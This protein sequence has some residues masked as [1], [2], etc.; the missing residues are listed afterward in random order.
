ML[1]SSLAFIPFFAIST[2][3]MAQTYS[4]PGG[5][6][7]FDESGDFAGTISD[8]TPVPGYPDESEITDITGTVSSDGT[9]SGTYSGVASYN[10]VDGSGDVVS[11]SEPYSGSFTGGIADGGDYSVSWGG[12]EPGS[13]TG[14]LSGF[15]L[16]SGPVTTSVVSSLTSPTEDIISS[17]SNSTGESRDYYPAKNRR[18]AA[19]VQDPNYIA[20]KLSEIS[21]LC[22]QTEVYVVDCIAERLEV[23]EKELRGLPGQSEV[24]KV[25]RQTALDLHS[26]A[27]EHR[28]P[29]T[30]RA[31]VRTQDNSLQTSR[32]LTAIAPDQKEAALIKALTIIEEAET[33]LLRSASTSSQAAQFQDI[34][35]ALGSNK[36]LLRAG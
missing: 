34:A 10:T 24:Q 32:P 23:L 6:I 11:V 22:S 7:T 9:I 31:N 8:I 3:T 2:L 12:V 29:A 30:P 21:R 35:S 16:P 5:A 15:S 20:N 17:S 14:N 26:V 1:K 27:R 18:A 28:D 36:V 4:V 25:L 13:N 19:A 33:Q